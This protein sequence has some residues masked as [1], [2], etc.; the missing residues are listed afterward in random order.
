[1]RQ[2]FLFALIGAAILSGCASQRETVD[3]FKVTD[4]QIGELGQR[5]T[6]IEASVARLEESQK[7]EVARIDGAH[8]REVA[9]IDSTHQSN[10]ARI[11]ET[12]RK[13]VARLDAEVKE[14]LRI[15]K[16]KFVYTTAPN[17]VEVLFAPGSAKLGSDAVQAL[18][19]LAKNLL[20]ANKNVYVEIRGFTDATGSEYQNRVLAL[21]R[22][23]SV[24]SALSESGV[25]L[26]RLSVIAVV[27]RESSARLSAQERAQNRR[28]TVS[29]VE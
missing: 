13:D 23:E 16:G 20:S 29:I 17:Q 11:D 3:K 25:A 26:H 18:E 15:A 22:A 7:R 12:Q 8:Q 1:M 19:N 28:V 14:A 9:R 27:D 2:K 4:Q 21:A 10:V 6:R 5:D 24:R